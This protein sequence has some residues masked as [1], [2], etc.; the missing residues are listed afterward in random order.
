MNRKI[1]VVDDEQIVLATLS[2]IFSKEGYEV[3]TATNGDDTL[4][5]ME[6]EGVKVFMLDLNMPKMNGLEL[7]RKIKA[8]Q[9]V[10]C[11]YALTGYASEFTVELCRK[12]GF[13]D[14]FTKPFKVDQMVEAAFAAFDKVKRWE[15][16]GRA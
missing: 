8:R 3:F 12:A 15:E 14:Y 16:H 2:K 6:E 11:V 10:S 4:R 13:D 5:I 1:M 7:C 9:P